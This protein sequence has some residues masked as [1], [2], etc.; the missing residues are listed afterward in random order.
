MRY[1]KLPLTVEQQVALLESRGM[2]IHDHAVAVQTLRC[3]SYYRLSAYWHPFKTEGDRFAPGT[4]FSRAL[5][6]YEFDRHLRL[7]VMDAIERVEVRLRTQATY[8]F[9]HAFGAMGHVEPMNFRRDFNHAAWIGKV[10]A[11]A[12]QSQEVFIEHFRARYDGFPDL[13][14]WMATEVIP[15]GALSRFYEGMRPAEQRLI[16]A[17]H[18][19]HHSVLRSWLRTLAYVRNLCAHHARLWNRELAVAPELPRHDGRWQP[20]LTP[21]N[22]RLFAVLLL[23][24][25][26]LAEHHAGQHWRDRCHDLMIRARL[27]RASQEAMGLPLAWDAHPLW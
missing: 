26:L 19:I 4:H 25:Q 8:H 7:L 1:D 12:K 20:P 14:L 13:P 17:G 6:L 22:R 9:S 2:V 11:E 3:I 21:S 15:F 18:G 5:E 27:N 23:L 16:A 10:R 24:R